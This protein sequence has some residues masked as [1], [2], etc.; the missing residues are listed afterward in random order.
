MINLLTLLTNFIAESFNQLLEN[1]GPRVTSVEGPMSQLLD[2]LPEPEPRS[3]HSNSSTHTTQ[4]ISLTSIKMA[5]W[6]ARKIILCCKKL[7]YCAIKT[8]RREGEMN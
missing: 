3:V 8:G 2:E 6:A 1:Y 4:V 5:N 7:Q